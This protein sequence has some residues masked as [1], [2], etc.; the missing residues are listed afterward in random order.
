ML[1]LTLRGTPTLYYG[2]ELGMT[3]VPIPAERQ[4]D[5]ARFGPEGSRD[6]ERTP[7]RWDGTARAG[8]TTGTP[9]LPLGDDLATVNVE[10]QR[11]DERSMVTL[12]RRLLALRRANPALEIGAW[13]PLAASG[14]LLAYE[15][16][17]TDRRVMD[18][19]VIV[20]LNLGDREM[21]AA[22]GDSRGRIVLSTHLDRESEAVSATV[23][24]RASEGVVI[25]AT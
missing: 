23:T 19:R 2:D 9:W 20:A 1:L 22:I 10:A 14:G 21:R 5:P 6:P 18:R 13:Q 7:M 16:R 24:L 25:D 4:Q 17:V 11:A 8:F 15:R 3:N 12:H